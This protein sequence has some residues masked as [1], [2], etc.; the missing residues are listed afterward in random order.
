[1]VADLAQRIQGAIRLDIGDPDFST[2]THVVDAIARAAAEGHTHYGPARGL[3][4]RRAA[5]AEDF[6][7]R[8]GAPCE[9]DR[10]V[11][12]AGAAGGLFCALLTLVDSGDEVLL[13]D[14][15]WANL[16]PMTLA[17]GGRPVLYP[18]DR[19]AGFEPD[20]DALAGLIGPRTR[21]IVV[22][23]PGN[24]TGAVLRAETLTALS[25]LAAEHGV[26]VISDECYDRFVFEGAH[27]G[28]AGVSPAPESVLTVCSFSK[29]YAMTGWRLGYVVAAPEISDLVA[30]MQEAVLSC[31]STP[32]QKG[33]EA[34]LAGPQTS[35]TEMRTAYAQRR[36]VALA[37][38]DAHGVA[39]VRPRGAFYVM[40]DVSPSGESSPDFAA[41]L[42]AESKV[43]VVPGNAFGAHGE[44]LVRVSLTASEDELAAGLER[45]A[46][47]LATGKRAA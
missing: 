11:V 24:P 7:R 44:G 13:P 30:R 34:A 22:N 10:I 20:L 40:V 28:T 23:S 27:V 4:S 45:L 14:P 26:W 16:V 9:P 32:V 19:D 8:E 5:I 12:T 18:L 2:P 42:L 43:A 37:T 6:A 46:Q 1:V 21:A 35:V 31:P 15:G 47:T 29:T 3:P 36:E 17:A 41:R 39:Y 25:T 38:L 33:A